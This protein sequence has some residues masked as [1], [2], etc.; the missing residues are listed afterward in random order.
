MIRQVGMLR[1]VY[2]YG[3]MILPNSFVCGQNLKSFY[4]TST[5]NQTRPFACEMVD[6]KHDF[7]PSLLMMGAAKHN[8]GIYKFLN[9][10][11]WVSKN[12]HPNQEYDFM[13]D[14]HAWLAA[15][16]KKGEWEIVDGAKIGVKTKLKQP[17]LVDDLMEETFLPLDHSCVG[18][19][20]PADEIL[21]RFKY[22]L[23]AAISNEQLMTSEVGIVRY[24]K[25]SMV[26]A[27][28]SKQLPYQVSL[29]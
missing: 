1:L 28:L 27:K 10:Y 9:Y 7:T 3:G 8:D 4:E 24:M 23:F 26:D 20:I 14:T 16:G 12:P 15:A 6:K 21:S 25:S 5:K 11:E 13:G 2:L 22:Q 18:V 29:L 17:M 19:F